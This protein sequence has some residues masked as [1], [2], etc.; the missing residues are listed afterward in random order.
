MTATVLSVASRAL[1][2]ACARLQI[3]TDAILARAG[4]ERRSIL[5]PDARLSAAQADAIWAAAHLAANDKNLPLRAASALPQGA[6]RVLDFVVA[7]A[8]TLTLALDRIVRYFK[9]VDQRAFLERGDGGTSLRFSSP[10]GPVPP[11]AQQYTLA[12]LATRLRDNLGEPLALNAARFA[13]PRPESIS[14]YEA[15]FRCPLVFDAPWCGL[16]FDA[17]A[18]DE[19]MRGA[20]HELGSVLV[21]HAEHLLATLPQVEPGLRNRVEAIIRAQLCHDSPS[22]SLVAKRLGLSERSLV[23]RLREEGTSFTELLGDIRT[24]MAREFLAQPEISLSEISWMLGFSEQSAWTRAFKRATGKSPSAWRK[25][26][27]TT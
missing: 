14:D 24:E 20:N 1:L 10:F 4:V 25:S 18:L 5:D 22:A 3:D 23:R 7:H 9:L 6:Y 17:S 27:F 11:E 21:A 26:H 12:A 19:P 16:V 13:F 2:E 15:I 8:P